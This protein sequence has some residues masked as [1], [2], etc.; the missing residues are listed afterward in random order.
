MLAPVRTSP[1]KGCTWSRKKNTTPGSAVKSSKA[2]E[3][4]ELLQGYSFLHQV[5]GQTDVIEKI[6]TPAGLAAATGFCKR[7]ALGFFEETNMDVSRVTADSTEFLLGLHSYMGL[8]VT[9]KPDQDLCG[10]RGEAPL[11]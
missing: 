10:T 8:H 5:W 2:G 4:A 9:E 6:L 1:Q 7:F 11:G 3:G